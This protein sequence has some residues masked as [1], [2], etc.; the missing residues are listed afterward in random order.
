METVFDYNITDKEREYI[1]INEKE[2]YLRHLSEDSANR[3]LASLFHLRG[4]IKRMKMY[5]EKLPLFMKWSF[6]RLIYHP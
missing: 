4:D 6:Y 5:A 3:G 2:Y 1:G